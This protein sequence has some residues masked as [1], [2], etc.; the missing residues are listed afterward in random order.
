VQVSDPHVG[1]PGDLQRLRRVVADI[2]KLPVEVDFVVVT[3]DITDD[4]T[5]DPET[6]LAVLDLFDTLEAPVHYVAGNHDV[7]TPDARHYR[8][9][10]GPL[11]H[12]TEHEGVALLFLHTWPLGRGPAAEGYDA[13]AWLAD[14]LEA[15]KGRPVLVFHHVPSVED[16][17]GH[18][19][20]PGWPEPHRRRWEA[21]FNGYDV[22]AVVAGHFHR[23]EHHWLGDVPLYIGP[24]T[25]GKYDRQ[26]SYRL[27]EY[28]DG[29][30]GYRTFY[31]P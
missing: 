22:R 18:K 16:L 5:D 27:Y 4:R 3:G 17:W 26:A 21:L 19:L 10:F 12:R 6:V 23:A 30:L 9:V 20:H 14:A 13:L 15:T 28:R 2:P 11:A 29:R 24:A 31:L 8:D 25:S 7:L 1:I